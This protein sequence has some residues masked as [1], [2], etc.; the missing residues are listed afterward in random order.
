MQIN[1]YLARYYIIRISR[2]I[3]I[4]VLVG[5]IGVGFVVIG[6][7]VIKGAF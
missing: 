6:A 2:T 3:G 5:F 7:E 1:E 4:L